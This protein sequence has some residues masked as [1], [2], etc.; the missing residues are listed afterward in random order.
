MGAPLFAIALYI[1]DDEEGSSSQER[2]MQDIIS[3]DSGLSF[4]SPGWWEKAYTA[5]LLVNP[6]EDATARSVA[7]RLSS[8]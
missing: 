1:S 2:R 5:R 3:G 4:L 8:E 6:P 7:R